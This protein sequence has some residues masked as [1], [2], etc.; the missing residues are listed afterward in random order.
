MTTIRQPL[1]TGPA[2]TN[3]LSAKVVDISDSAVK[4][5]ERLFANLRGRW[6]CAPGSKRN[7]CSRCSGS[8][9]PPR[10]SYPRHSPTTCNPMFF[11]EG[12]DPDPTIEGTAVAHDP[13]PVWAA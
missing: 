9:R 5:R 8:T 7:T 13:L 11:N 2:K 1:Q 10:S 4:T 6:I 3:E 12:C